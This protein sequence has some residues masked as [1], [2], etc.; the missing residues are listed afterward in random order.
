MHPI[1]YDLSFAIHLPVNMTYEKVETLF[2][3]YPTHSVMFCLI[4]LPMF[5]S[6][7]GH[8]H[9]D[10]QDVRDAQQRKARIDA[11]TKSVRDKVWHV[12]SKDAVSLRW[13]N[14]ACI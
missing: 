5:L 4:S 11:L 13:H 14:E 3:W 7:S 8:H 10:L 12:S 6:G 1:I 2:T 9:S